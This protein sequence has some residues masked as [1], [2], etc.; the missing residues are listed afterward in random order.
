MPL[1]IFFNH[2]S[3]QT[4][5]HNLITFVR[6]ILDKCKYNIFLLCTKSNLNFPDRNRAIIHLKRSKKLQRCGSWNCFVILKRGIIIVNCSPIIFSQSGLL[7]ANSQSFKA[8]MKRA[9]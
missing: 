4:H 5:C 7:S 6:A 1:N 3:I 8:N 9:L 2:L